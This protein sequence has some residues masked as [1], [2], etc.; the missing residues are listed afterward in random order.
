MFAQARA[1]GRHLEHLLLVTHAG[2]LIDHAKL[3]LRAAQ[4]VRLFA[5]EEYATPRGNPLARAP[6]A[7]LS[8]A[9]MARTPPPRLALRY[10][11]DIPDDQR[12]SFR[13]SPQSCLFHA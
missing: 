5:R 4:R 10:G 2:D 8:G 9:D 13:A 3:A 12:M 1:G 7:R 11:A 6:R